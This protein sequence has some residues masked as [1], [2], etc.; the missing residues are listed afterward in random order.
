M[1]TLLSHRPI[2]NESSKRKYRW[3]QLQPPVSCTFFCFSTP[4]SSPTLSPPCLSF[5]LTCLTSIYSCNIPPLCSCVFS[6]PHYYFTLSTVSA[7]PLWS[8]E[9]WTTDWTIYFCKDTS[10]SNHS[11]SRC[12]YR[13]HMH[14][15]FWLK[16]SSQW[17]ESVLREKKTQSAWYMCFP[18]H[19]FTSKCFLSTHARLTFGR[20]E[21]KERESEACETFP[22]SQHAFSSQF[23]VKTAH[24]ELCRKKKT[25]TIQSWAIQ[26]Y[27]LLLFFTAV[28]MPYAAPFI[29][30][31][32]S[33]LKM[34]T[35]GEPE[36]SNLKL[37]ARLVD[38]NWVRSRVMWEYQANHKESLLAWQ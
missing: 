27:F 24:E 28:I 7:G 15:Y 34:Q 30:W 31:Q 38:F 5:L 21:K 6:P 9:N 29:R 11:I 10:V 26:S 12:L 25:N 18:I 1:P 13:T 8:W 22:S 32:D 19:F 20:M 14:G 36:C 37:K 17:I 2:R 23:L 3:N 35:F 16:H 4:L 33:W